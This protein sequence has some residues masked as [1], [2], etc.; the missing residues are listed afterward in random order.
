MSVN[1]LVVRS[2][3]QVLRSGD[4]VSVVD[5][6]AS[7]DDR[8]KIEPDSSVP[9]EVIYE[10]DDVMVVNKPAGVVVHPGN[11]NSDHT[12]VNGLVHHCG[13]NLAKLHNDLRPGI[14]HRID[15]DTSGILVIAKNDFAHMK[16]AEQFAVHSIKR[17]YVCFIYSTLRPAYGKIET[18]IG[19]SDINRLKMAVTPGRGK[20]AITLYKTIKTFGSY[21]SKIECELKT[22]RTHQIR[23]HLSSLGC[24]LIGD[25]LYKVK[26]YPM[27]KQI[28][29]EINK[30]PRQALHAYFLEFIHPKTEKTLKFE[31]NMPEDMRNLEIILG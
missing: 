7:I 3:S 23:V 15:K 18:L 10:D 29:E 1:S 4:L 31:C 27:P 30:F 24:S 12:L 21:A 2:S 17:K 28:A 19:R 6:P 25:A 5:I 11:G 16:L 26:N 20:N 8:P 9:F 22:G 14:V 13:E